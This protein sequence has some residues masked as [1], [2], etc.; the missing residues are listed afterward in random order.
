MGQDEPGTNGAVPPPPPPDGLDWGRSDDPWAAPPASDPVAVVEG[1]DVAWGLDRLESRL[2]RSQR[3]DRENLTGRLDLLEQ[4]LADLDSRAT[5]LPGQL[6]G[7]LTGRL[8]ALAERVAEADQRIDVRTV[9]A[10]TRTEEAIRDAV[11]GLTARFEV[12]LGGVAEQLEQRLDAAVGRL[13]SELATRADAT[14][15][16]ATQATTA[17]QEHLEATTRALQA[18]LREALTA[19]TAGL[20][21]RADERATRAA[22]RLSAVGVSVS[23]DLA[24]LREDVDTRTAAVR[25]D[26][27]AATSAL[28]DELEGRAAALAEALDARTAAL[29]DRTREVA[30]LTRGLASTVEAQGVAAVER[31][32]GDVDRAAATERAATE[33]H[34]AAVAAAAERHAALERQLGTLEGELATQVDALREE[35]RATSTTLATSQETSDRRTAHELGTLRVLLSGRFDTVDTAA[36]ELRDH[37]D[38]LVA[39]LEQQLAVERAATADALAELDDQV[40]TT[41]HDGVAKVEAR[42]L[43]ADHG[44]R[45]RSEQLVAR[46]AQLDEEVGQLR[47]R[48]DAALTSLTRT[49]EDHRAERER[50]V[51]SLDALDAQLRDLPATVARSGAEVRDALDEHAELAGAA[52]ETIEQ[53]GGRLDRIDSTLAVRIPDLIGRLRLGVV[54]LDAALGQ[55]RGGLQAF[56][57]I[58]ERN[59]G[60]LARW[61]DGLSSSAR[62]IE[63]K[64]TDAVARAADLL[65]DETAGSADAVRHAAERLHRASNE[66]EGVDETLRE[67]IVRWER[68]AGAEHRALLEQLVEQLAADL[69]ARHRRKVAEQLLTGRA[70]G[71]AS[72]EALEIGSASAEAPASEDDAPADLSEPE[73]AATD[74]PAED[75]VSAAPSEG[76]LSTDERDEPDGGEAD[77]DEAVRAEVPSEAPVSIREALEGTPGIGPARLTALVDR[78]GTLQR[79]AAADPAEVAQLRGI[80]EEAARTVVAAAADHLAPGPEDPLDDA[81]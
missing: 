20:D 34:E 80:S 60:A 22:D 69:P 43:A 25:A 67:R 13:A 74:V 15:E 29:A 59:D 16:A 30:E 50:L 21:A 23:S 65:V 49:A 48:L 1:S 64:L 26:L 38:A 5:A 40:Q 18:E 35:L 31:A 6:E 41:V 27:D 46:L 3:A 61:S 28:R 2:L 11:D 51:G 73:A 12:R 44:D 70:A 39:R 52:R 42:L 45:Q 62:A 75:E 17:A 54:E 76:S 56:E 19:A 14:A 55:L 10:A 24:D 9:D 63:A 33:R 8:D 78:F 66:L 32:A 71:S 7:R 68:R 81:R 37:L 4:R 58:V 57:G 47:G 77:G 53:F 72:A 79:L 36:G